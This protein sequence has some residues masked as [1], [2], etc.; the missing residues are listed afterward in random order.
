MHLYLSGLPLSIHNSVLHSVYVSFP[1]HLSMLTLYVC[2]C[3]IRSYTVSIY[4]SDGP[5]CRCYLFG[6]YGDY[7]SGLY[8]PLAVSV[9]DE[10]LSIFRMEYGIPISSKNLGDYTTVVLIP[11]LYYCRESLNLIVNYMWPL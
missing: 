11:A 9:I 10:L 1:P 5:T 4:L 7:L 2:L 3:L 6:M 8:Q